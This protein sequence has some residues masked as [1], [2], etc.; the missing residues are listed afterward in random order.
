MTSPEI[1]RPAERKPS[2]ESEKIDFI[3]EILGRFYREE[4]ILAK[5][6][7]EMEDGSLH[8]DFYFP[9]YDRSESELGHVSVVQMTAAVVEAAYL[10]LGIRLYR[11][12][13]LNLPFNE[14]VSSMARPL[15]SSD[16]RKFRKLL[17]EESEATLNTKIKTLKS[18]DTHKGA[19]ILEF[20]GFVEGNCIC[21]LLPNDH[22]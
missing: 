4:K 7:T 1:R 9:K 5:R 2:P 6:V 17:K 10:A 14:F 22:K 11:D 20:E 18:S 15:Y 16:K 8:I 12:S 19:A 13:S 3:K 21:I